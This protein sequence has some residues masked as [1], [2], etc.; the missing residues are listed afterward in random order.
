MANN[1][2]ATTLTLCRK[3]MIQRLSCLPTASARRKGEYL[4]DPYIK[5]YFNDDGRGYLP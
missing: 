5:N 1:F 2:A 3:A 4:I